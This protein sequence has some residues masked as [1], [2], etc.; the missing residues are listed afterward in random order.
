M[1]SRDARA[2]DLKMFSFGRRSKHVTPANPAACAQPDDVQK[3]KDM[4]QD[5][6][7]KYEALRVDFMRMNAA[8]S[9]LD[10]DMDAVWNEF[11]SLPKPGQFTEWRAELRRHKFQLEQVQGQIRT[12]ERTAGLKFEGMQRGQ[13]KM[14]ANL[15]EFARAGVYQMESITWLKDCVRAIRDHRPIPDM[16]VPSEPEN[17]MVPYNDR[18]KVVLY[19]PPPGS[20]DE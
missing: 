7:D 15:Q 14:V 8:Q 1:T 6:L 18:R 16:P 9:R 13:D 12:A 10:H 5:I 3:L 17:K 2:D 11:D 20:D 4:Y 19:N